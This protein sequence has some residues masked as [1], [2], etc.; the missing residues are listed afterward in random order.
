MVKN[1]NK[2]IEDFNQIKEDI[3]IL[4]KNQEIKYED[5]EN[6]KLKTSDVKKYL[7]DL[8]KGSKPEIALR[9]DLLYKNSPLVNFLF[10]NI[11]HSPEVKENGFV[12]YIIMD[13]L[14][15]KIVIELKSLFKKE[16]TNK[17]EKLIK[18]DL[19]WRNHIDQIKKYIFIGDYVILTNLE[20][21]I[22]FGRSIDIQDPKPFLEINFSNFINEF[23]GSKNLKEYADRKEYEVE[24]G[25]LDQKFLSDLK[26]WVNLLLRIEFQQEIDE[27]NK[28]DK[29]IGVINKFIFIQT[30]DDYGVIPFRWIYNNWNSIQ[31][32]W[33]RKGELKVL[34]EFLKLVNDWFYLYY[35][36]E[37]FKE[38]ILN[39]INKRDE[40]IKNLY[41]YLKLI[42]GIENISKGIK[43]KGIM[44][45]N[46]RHIDEDVL[47]KS[48]E[49]FLAEKRKEKGAYYTP[50]YITEYIVENTVLPIFNEY[51][52]RIKEYIRND[53]Y[54]NA[55]V[56]IDYLIN[57][58]VIDP[59]CGSGSFLI[60]SFR[61]IYYKYKEL[62]N[63]I[64]AQ[65]SKY[66]KNNKLN[67]DE[68]FNRLN[69]LKQKLSC[70]EMDFDLM[71]SC[72]I[73]RHIFGV[74]M[75]KKA[76]EIAKLNIW[77]EI[78]KLNP[79][80]FKYDNLPSNISHI[81]PDLRM[82]L[83]NGD[84]LIGL[85]FDKQIEILKNYKDEINEM[86]KLRKEYINNPTDNSFIDRIENIKMSI[87][88][89]MDIEFEKNLTE[90]NLLKVKDITIPFHW[91]LEF[92]FAFN[93]ENK[94]YGFDAVIGNPPWGRLKQIIED[95]EIKDILGKYY[96]Q[97]FEYQHGNFNNYKL[98]LER[99]YNILKERGYFSMIFPS[100]FLGEKDSLNLRR[101]FFE[102]AITIKIIEMP[103]KAK[104]FKDV[105]QDVVVWV[106]KKE[107]I[108]Q[109]YNFAICFGIYGQEIDL[110]NLPYFSFNKNDFKILT[111]EEYR[112]PN[113]IDPVNEV[114]ILNKISNIPPFKGDSKQNIPSI[115]EIYEGELHETFDKEFLSDEPT[116]DLII[117]GIH[118]DQFFV[119]YDPN[120]P[121]PR[122]VKKNEFL[123]KKDVKNKIENARIIGRST[124]NRFIR[125]RL[126]F[127]ALPPK[128]ITTNSIKSI[129]ITDDRV[130]EYYLIGLLNSILLNWRFELFSFQNSVRNYEIESL[131]IIR[132]NANN[133]DIV[134]KI[135]DLTKQIIDLK[136]KSY[137]WLNTDEKISN[138][139][140]TLYEILNDD[141]DKFI[142]KD[143]KRFFQHVKLYPDAFVDDEFEIFH[144]ELINDI[145]NAKY[146]LSIY[147]ISKKNPSLTLLNKF[148]FLDRN[149]AELF[150]LFIMKTLKSKLRI[151]TMKDLAKKTI[152]PL[153]QPDMETSSPN[154][155]EHLKDELINENKINQNEYL[156]D[157][158]KK[159]LDLRI[160]L[161]KLIFKLY[162]INEND[163]KIIVKCLLDFTK[164]SIDPDFFNVLIRI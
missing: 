147:G 33:E 99:S 44:Q 138:T 117:K 151:K 68:N 142:K 29:I 127:S 84:S 101:L 3:E 16:K 122:W 110:S 146:E 95:K 93:I 64:D 51:T 26:N 103:E 154:V 22:F 94:K 43:F 1:D 126:I 23:S 152:I 18:N 75:D 163:I 70:G 11:Q 158:N 98:F 8:F 164:F 80:K 136:Q 92:W 133:I 160:E 48:Y 124:K 134:N 143:N 90:M 86:C 53:D 45:Y 112:L 71:D 46:F 15:H 159:I 78:I 42:L 148:S 7:N 67:Y 82:N 38:N 144:V 47:G 89:S 27:K 105:T 17:S 115:G 41:D 130:D 31:N 12:D 13:E 129:F 6:S 121:K 77:L 153:I 132:S 28:L 141:K 97:M 61:K 36:T 137:W 128:Y 91:I 106:Y 156:S 74:D 131:P 14:G 20:Y 120:G 87:K 32:L 24:K 69:S 54:G 56:Y 66:H 85:N 145:N 65:L 62:L 157:L 125:P 81:L 39:Y 162:N 100:S 111:N 88:N 79:Q 30:L 109:N 49:L 63:M 2:E 114:R 118:L 50:K 25:E 9:E 21:W 107:K 40:N 149:T 161:E 102:N 73:L 119:N 57:I 139:N 5:I 108:D 19:N 4:I 135:S 60:K 116:G 96:S 123:A 140:R 150:Y 34:E 76:L 83:R 72:I 155:I 52:D 113:F 55:D 37:L 59:A 58:K 35:D 104:T 10:K